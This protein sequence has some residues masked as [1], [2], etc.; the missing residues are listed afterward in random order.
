MILLIVISSY[1]KG[2]LRSIVLLVGYAASVFAALGLSRWL[3]GAVFRQ[4]LYH[5]IVDSVNKTV[6]A[7]AEGIPF[8][9]VLSNVFDKLPG[10]VVNPILATFGGEE[11]IISDLQSSTGGA[12]SLLGKS[13]TDTVISP[14]VTLLLQMLFCLL[15][16]IIC[17]IIVKMIAS[18][19]KRF[20][21]IPILGPVNSLL[22]GIVGILKAV[23]ILYILAIAASFMISI[24]ANQL[25][26]FNTDIIF[27]SHIFNGFYNF[28]NH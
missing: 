9:E 8:S 19:F 6:G 3:S 27:H 14:V 4:F 22:G 23:V 20:Y 26:W 12:L 24:T 18:L 28:A 5:P 13:L 25:S 10:F 17:V 2:F 11:K 16:F 21:K 7:T 1:K 15:I